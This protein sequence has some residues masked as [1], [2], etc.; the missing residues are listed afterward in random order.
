MFDSGIQIFDS[1][2]DPLRD[3][4]EMVIIVP[5]IPSTSVLGYEW[6]IPTGLLKYR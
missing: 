5:I 3:Y 2:V 4:S 6:G 1:M